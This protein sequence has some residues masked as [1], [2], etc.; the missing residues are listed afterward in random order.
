[1]LSKRSICRAHVTSPPHHLG[2][3]QRTW[4]RETKRGTKALSSFPL[5]IIVTS[6]VSSTQNYKMLEPERELTQSQ[7]APCECLP[8]IHSLLLVKNNTNNFQSIGTP[9]SHSPFTLEKL[10][11]LQCQS[12]PIPWPHLRI[13]RRACCQFISAVH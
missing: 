8:S 2:E 4:E 1:M 13:Q 9:P 12:R 11:P 7:R 6:R 10:V 3:A 5:L